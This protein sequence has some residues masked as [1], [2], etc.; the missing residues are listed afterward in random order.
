ML[1]NEEL[2]SIVDLIEKREGDLLFRGKV[3]NL[4]DHRDAAY[5]NERRRPV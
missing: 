4:A 5:L 1:T 3:E 2:A